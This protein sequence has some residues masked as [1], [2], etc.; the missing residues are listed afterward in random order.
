MKVQK[1]VTETSEEN[2]SLSRRGD[3]LTVELMFPPRTDGE[4]NANARYVLV[5]QS[6]V[7]ASDGVR[8]FYDYDRD[9]FVVQQPRVRMIKISDG[10]Y[11]S[12]EDWTEVGFFQSWALDDDPLSDEKFAEADR[13]YEDNAK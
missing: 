5:N 13:I 12:V 6:S 8:L 4:D 3:E 7:R 9:G 10:G 11:D 1:I 2:F